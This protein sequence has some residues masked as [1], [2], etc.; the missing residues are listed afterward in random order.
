MTEQDTCPQCG[1]K[2]ALANLY[3]EVRCW[4]DE[5]YEPGIRADVE[6]DFTC[7]DGDNCSGCVCQLTRAP[8]N[9]IAVK[10]VVAGRIT[11]HDQ[12]A[13]MGVV[14]EY[15]AAVVVILTYHAAGAGKVDDDVS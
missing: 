15:I 1:G 10:C 9:I 4:D 7:L 6:Q 2:M 11:T 14:G 13:C 8:Y 12:S 5:P 3:L